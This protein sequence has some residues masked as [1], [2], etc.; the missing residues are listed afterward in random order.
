M[1][2]GMVY[3]LG[4]GPSFRNWFEGSTPSSRTP[5]KRQ[6]RNGKRDRLKP[7]CSTEHAGSIPALRIGIKR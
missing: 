2:G 1:G 7:G 4:L 6:W 5:N 3:T